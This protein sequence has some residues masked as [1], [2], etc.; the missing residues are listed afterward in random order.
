[1]GDAGFSGRP[2]Y[3]GRRG[4]KG[5]KGD[6]GLIGFDGPEGEKGE[7]G[8]RGPPGLA[9]LDGLG[10]FVGETGD[11]APP[12]P[13]PKSR[14]Y[15]FTRHSQSVRL[16]ECPPNTD[17]LWHGYSLAA[18]IGGSRTVGQDL[19]N[20][21]SCMRRFSP[22][23]FLMCDVNNVCNYAQN[24]DDS[25]WL[26][27]E[28][29]M[30]MSM[31]PMEGREIEPYVSRC[32]VCETTTRLIALHSQSMDIPTCPNGWEEMWYGYSFMMHTIDNNGGSGQNLL[33]PGSCLEEFRTQP[34]IECHGHGKCNYYDGLSSFWMSVI[35][36]G[37]QW[38]RPRMQTLKAD[39]TAKVSRCTVCRKIQKI[40]QPT[41]LPG[42]SALIGRTPAYRPPPPPP[43]RRRPSNYRGRSG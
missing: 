33:S 21:G 17:L 18:L 27:T 23:P 28:E 19:G 7:M 4:F 26:S 3:T 40:R 42:A 8:Y 9:G 30:S 5:I 12:P 37:E 32:A 15:V 20:A 36:E 41:N 25:V 14:G 39:H 34:V 31:A 38:Q 6:I 1:M 16:P 24:N 35:E 43:P 22:M 29:P 10:G 13:P 11:P 2:G